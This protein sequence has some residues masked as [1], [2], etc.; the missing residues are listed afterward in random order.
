MI[1]R[2]PIFTTLLAGAASLVCPT[3]TARAVNGASSPVADA[4]SA[5]TAAIWRSYYDEVRVWGY[6]DRHSID[7]GQTFNLMLSTGPNLKGCKGRI[8]IYRIGYYAG[9]DRE[10]AWHSETVEVFQQPVQVTAASAGTGWTALIKQIGTGGWRSGYYTI[11]F[12]DDADGWRDLDV[13]FIVVTDKDRS[14]NILLELSSNTW[15]AYNEWGGYSLYASDFIGDGAQAISFDRPTPPDFLEYEYYL[16]LWLER[17]A[18]ERNLKVDYATN[19]DVHRDAAFTEN[20]PL[21]ISGAHNEYWSLEEFEAVYRRIFGLGKNTI[22]MG[23]NTAY[24]QVRYADVNGGGADAF[25]GRQLVCFKSLDDPV[26]FRGNKERSFDLITMRFRDGAR[27]P[28]TMLM[29]VAYQSWFNPETI[30]PI[31]YPYFVAR[32]DLP[33]FA[34]TGYEVGDRIGDVV[35]YEWDNTDPDGDGRRLWDSEKSRIPPIDPA[36][37][38]ILFTGSPVD[39]DGK[40][41]KAEAA[42]FV[43]PAGAKVFS[44]GSIRWAWGLGAP[45]F[46]EERFKIFN[47]N[48]LEHFL[49]PA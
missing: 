35:G 34:G 47:R 25:R 44:S 20:Y 23:A 42:Y 3:G 12:V 17:F 16:V 28:E 7:P 26:R 6:A 15:Q 14:G 22:F 48:L 8:E 9:S 37:I 38:K 10:L 30:P 29:G 46:E 33:F 13:A 45:G 32:N 49:Q 11:D 19:F 31:S 41:G 40:Q 39:V 27:R 18:T 2:R 21:F 1:A 36:S 5:M 43:S 24:W 4:K